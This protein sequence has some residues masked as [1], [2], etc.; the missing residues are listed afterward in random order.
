MRI[1]GSFVAVFYL[2]LNGQAQSLLPFDTLKPQHDFYA[3]ADSIHAFLQ[4]SRSI[5]PNTGLRDGI[6]AEPLLLYKPM[7]TFIQH[8]ELEEP[9]PVFTAL[10]FIGFNYAF[11]TQGSQHLALY[12]AQCFKHGWLVNAHVLSHRSQGFVR[13]NAWKNRNILVDL[14][15][16]TVHWKTHLHL[17]NAT[18]YRQFSGGIISDSL[19]D[20]IGLNLVPVRKDSCAATVA[21]RK[22]AWKN[23]FN[24]R[25]DSVGFFGIIHQSSLENWGRY[26]VENDTL[27][28]LYPSIFYDSL[29]T[30][31]RFELVRTKNA[32]GMGTSLQDWRFEL[33]S[34]ADYWRMRMKGVQR[35]TLEIG[36][37]ANAYYRGKK[38]V[39]MLTYQRNI[40][41]GFNASEIIGRLERVFPGGFKMGVSMSYGLKA[42]EVLQ[43]FYYGNTFQNGM[44]SLSLQ[45]V[46]VFQGS[47][48]GRILGTDYFI[49]LR[50]LITEKVYQFNGLVW[51]AQSAASSQQLVDLDLRLVKTWKGLAI[52][53]QFHYLMQKNRILPSCGIGGSIA[54][55]GYISK[56]KNLFFFSKINYQCYM[57]YKSIGLIP[58]LSLLDVIHVNGTE[59]NYHSLNALLGFKVKTFQFYLSGDNLG[60]FFM[61]NQQVLFVNLPV[62][63]WQIK[64][65]ITWVFWN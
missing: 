27:F 64:M 55:Q 40:M 18:D 23:E 47:A 61:P 63:S 26:F 43:R 38:S 52:A 48:S 59:M 32:L 7:G 42:P 34:N 50:A 31:D 12:Y 44:S 2:V 33:L 28:G 45:K 4:N 5:V 46:A 54:Y 49:R 24:L 36:L 20:V 17:E 6:F 14:A 37:V 11:G 8:A 56:R 25:R 13:N 35:D 41:G 58:Q 10:P 57:G 22:I 39:G 62:P 51:D 65:G 60:A 53:P 30:N 9:T 29:L 1:F 3:T 16:Q 19:L 21:T 15:R